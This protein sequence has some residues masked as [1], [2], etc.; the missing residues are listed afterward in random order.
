MHPAI[1]LILFVICVIIYACSAN[2]I[3][4]KWQVVEIPTNLISGI[5]AVCPV[6]N[7]LL[8]LYYTYPEYKET[9]IKI[10]KK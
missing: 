10:F 6:L 4:T 2:T 8:A 7:T 1:I 9:F 3:L 5:F